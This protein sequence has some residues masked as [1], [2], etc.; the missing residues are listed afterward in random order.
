MGV[1]EDAL[2][3]TQVQAGLPQWLEGWWEAVPGCHGLP[4]KAYREDAEQVL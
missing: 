4:V 2:A 3:Q 1:V